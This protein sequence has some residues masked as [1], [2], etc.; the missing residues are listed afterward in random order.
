MK[1]KES[2]LVHLYRNGAYYKT[3]SVVFGSYESAEFYAKN[4]VYY[5][6]VEKVDFVE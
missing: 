2:Y 3:C 1:A 5:A 4:C 6:Q